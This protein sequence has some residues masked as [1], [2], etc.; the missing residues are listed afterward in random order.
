MAQERLGLPREQ[1]GGG[2]GT[3]RV[4]DSRL[5]TRRGQ[6]DTIGFPQRPQGR[7]DLPEGVELALLA[8][9]PAGG[10]RDAGARRGILRRRRRQHPRR[11]QRRQIAGRSEG[12]QRFD[13]ERIEVGAGELEQPPRPRPLSG[14]GGFE[15][16]LAGIG[17]RRR[18][19]GRDQGPGRVAVGADEQPQAVPRAHRRPPIGPTDRAERFDRSDPGRQRLVQHRDVDGRVRLGHLPRHADRRGHAAGHQGRRERVVLGAASGLA[20]RDHHQPHPRGGRVQRAGEPGRRDQIRP[21]RSPPQRHHRRLTAGCC[22]S[23]VS[24]AREV[25]DVRQPQRGPTRGDRFDTAIVG[26]RDPHSRRRRDRIA[27]PRQIEALSAID[28][29]LYTPQPQG[30]RRRRQGGPRTGRADGAGHHQLFEP[31]P[32]GE[33][34]PRHRQHQP[35]QPGQAHPRRRGDLDPQRGR[36]VAQQGGQRQAPVA[37]GPQPATDGHPPR[38]AAPRQRAGRLVL[39]HQRPHLRVICG[40]EGPRVPSPARSIRQRQRPFSPEGEP[41]RCVPVRPAVQRSS[42]RA[43]QPPARCRGR[44]AR[45][46]VVARSVFWV[47]VGWYRVVPAS[48]SRA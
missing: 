30:T 5:G 21:P 3:Q 18:P 48:A 6:G 14:V 23:G 17:E 43:P 47:G 37:P 34:L 20:G 9:V 11:A 12:S 4:P 16:A 36:R 41:P 35:G 26:V 45:T 29:G 32:D 10:D 27:L 13:G 22:R 31:I 7:Q 40:G 1:L 44:G 46:D 2:S 33:Q 39:V 24:V 42:D 8:G 15:R 28:V 38:Q 19:R 25:D